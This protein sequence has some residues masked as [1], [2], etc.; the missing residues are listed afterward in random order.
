MKDELD[1]ILFAVKQAKEAEKFGFTR[2]ICCRNLKIALH[3]YWQHKTLGFHGQIEKQN[4][5]RSKAARGKKKTECQVEHVIPQMMIV[6]MLMDMKKLS[7][8]AAKS[9]LEKYFH[10]LLVT[11][12]EHSRLNSSGL[13]SSMPDGWDEKNI[14]ARYE[15]VGIKPETRLATGSRERRR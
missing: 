9:V 7:K 13:R 10:V 11:N 2:N 14:W 3:H 6:N 4:I 5:P 8:P 1:F 12:E 15:A